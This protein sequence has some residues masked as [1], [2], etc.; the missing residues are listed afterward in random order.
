MAEQ[1]FYRKM[2]KEVG[3]LSVWQSALSPLFTPQVLRIQMFF[4]TE[5]LR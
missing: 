1:G 2:K 3:K 5:F 4:F